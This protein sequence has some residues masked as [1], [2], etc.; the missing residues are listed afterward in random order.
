MYKKTLSVFVAAVMVSL[1]A[2]TANAAISDIISNLNYGANAGITYSSLN[3][4]NTDTK[5][6]SKIGVTIGGTITHQLNDEISLNTG[7]SIAQRNADSGAEG[8]LKENKSMYL[9]VPGTVE[10]KLSQQIL[11]CDI[12]VQGGGYVGYLLSSEYNGSDNKD[13]TTTADYGVRLGASFTKV[14]PVSAFSNI[15]VN[16]GYDMGIKEIRSKTKSNAIVVSASGQF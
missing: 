4:D 10:Y 13:A 11:G 15:S 9:Q 16:V 7:A 2:S 5:T 3:I 8:A 14:S 12:A 1:G 6:E